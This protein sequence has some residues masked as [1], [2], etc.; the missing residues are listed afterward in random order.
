MDERYRLARARPD[1]ALR[2]WAHPTCPSPTPR[3]MPATESLQTRL[4]PAHVLY[5]HYLRTRLPRPTPRPPT[6]AGKEA[7]DTADVLLASDPKPGGRG[8]RS[9]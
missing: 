4:C 7:V 5:R 1:P 2:T 3:S 6:L 8:S 9:S